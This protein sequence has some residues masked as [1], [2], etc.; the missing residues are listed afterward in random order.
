VRTYPFS[1]PPVKPATADSRVIVAFAVCHVNGEAAGLVVCPKR[2]AE[3]DSVSAKAARDVAVH[4]NLATEAID[5]APR[6]LARTASTR[7][8]GSHPLFFAIRS[9]TVGVPLDRVMADIVTRSGEAWA[10]H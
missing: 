6:P 8:N 7:C 5:E 4:A 2:R 1:S 3:A 10:S 9:R